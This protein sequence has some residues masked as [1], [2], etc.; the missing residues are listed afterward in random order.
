[1]TEEEIESA[2]A[3]EAEEKAV[4]ESATEK[5]NLFLGFCT[6]K[7]NLDDT[8]TV[9]AFSDK[10]KKLS[11]VMENHDV[12][13]AVTVKDAERQGLVTSRDID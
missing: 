6:R 11:I 5:L 10:G 8:Y 1:M 12:V 2:I 4:I 7:F 3:D 13:V 9:Q